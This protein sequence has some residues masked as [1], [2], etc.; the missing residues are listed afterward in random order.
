MYL[1][2]KD[3]RDVLYQIRNYMPLF[4]KDK[5]LSY[6]KWA[7]PRIYELV[8]SFNIKKLEGFCSE[9]FIEKITKNKDVYRINDNID[10]VIV[11]FASLHDFVHKNDEEMYI[12]IYTSVYLHDNVLNNEPL[13]EELLKQVMNKTSNNKYWNDIW[14]VTYGKRKK[15]VNMKSANCPNCGAIMIFD[16]NNDLLKCNHCQNMVF[17]TIEDS[18]EWEIVDVEKI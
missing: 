5:I 10:R 18:E 17:G 14:I 16:K 2:R 15:F 1:R 7:V 11:Q 8:K 6:T 13:S 4:D 12:Q 9:K 3:S